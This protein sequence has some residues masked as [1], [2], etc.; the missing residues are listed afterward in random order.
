[1]LLTSQALY[2]I[3]SMCIDVLS[4]EFEIVGI[5]VSLMGFILFDVVAVILLTVVFKLFDG[6]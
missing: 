5:K 3:F 2:T 1:M 6:K 4:I